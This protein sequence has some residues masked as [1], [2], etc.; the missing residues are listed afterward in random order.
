MNEY[1]RRN[2]QSGTRDRYRYTANMSDQS[3]LAA[4]RSFALGGATD[5]DLLESCGAPDKWHTAISIACDAFEATIGP[6]DSAKGQSVALN[7]DLNA[8]TAEMN[9]LSQL[10]VT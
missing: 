6:Q 1:I 5:E 4:G 7:A 8:K 2:L 10:F 3:L 9:A